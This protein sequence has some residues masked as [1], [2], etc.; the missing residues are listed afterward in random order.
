MVKTSMDAFS[1]LF[2]FSHSSVK[3]KNE[4]VG[5]RMTLMM[6]DLNKLYNEIG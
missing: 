4:I 2:A 3:E 6:P 1:F 5:D